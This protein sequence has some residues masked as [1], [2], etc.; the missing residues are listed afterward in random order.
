MVKRA[1][2]SVS[3]KDGIEDFAK[4]LSNLGIEI[5]S[6]GGTAKALRNSGVDVVDV[7]EVTKFPEM[8]NGRVKTLHPNIHGAILAIR[9]NE[10]HLKDAKREGIEF[11]DMVVVNLYPFCET[12]SKPDVTV[13]EAIENIDIGG[14]AML[15]A[16]AKNFKYVTVVCNPDDYDSVLNELKTNGSVSDETRKRLAVSA[17]RHTA[18]Y[19]SAIDIYLSDALLSEKVK[20]LSYNS[21]VS[22]RYGENSHQ[23]ASFFKQANY[24]GPTPS[25]SVQLHGKALSYNNYVDI[26]NAYLTVRALDMLEK[27]CP[28]VAIVKH[29]NPCGV[30]TGGTLSEALSA[31]W[32]GDPVSAFG[33]IICSNRVFD[34]E[35]ARWLDGKFVEIIIA[36]GFE[37]DA[38][39]FLKNKSENLRILEMKDFA[40]PLNPDPVFKFVSG[41]LL[42]QTLDEGVFAKWECVTKEAF[43]DS[44]KELSAFA[45]IA[46]KCLKSN[47][48]TIAREYRPGYYMLL[49]MGAGQPN[50]VDSIRKLGL[51]K[52]GENLKIVYERESPDCS[53][54]DFQR[55]I[56][57]ECVMAS[58]AFFPFDDNIIFAHEGNI[59]Y[60]VSPGGSIRDSEVIETADRL[61]VS[62]VFTGMRHFLH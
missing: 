61:G 31:A 3:N 45:M 56:I 1:L 52:A 49:G 13:E 7:S 38:L 34:I 39:E 11:I 59:K 35:S 12:V 43:P 54:E 44:K 18:D 17:F 2:I 20:R 50:R 55:N 9:D 19:D 14:P 15:R 5:I 41:G 21:G 4:G 47:T 6:T 25:N 10:S 16:A 33:S 27:N 30:A 51:S 42:E 46:C 37:P 58:D 53:F 22:L 62:L 23:T 8:M 36:P 40:E 32:D 57:S 24:K 48:I 29:N 26:E 28:A 60:V